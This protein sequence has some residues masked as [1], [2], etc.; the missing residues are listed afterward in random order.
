MAGGKLYLDNQPVAAVI[1]TGVKTNVVSTKSRKRRNRRRGKKVYDGI[2]KAV[3]L[4]KNNV[5]IIR[6]THL[7]TLPKRTLTRHDMTVRMTLPGSS[8][9]FNY[10]LIKLNSLEAPFSE[11]ITDGWAIAQNL[12]PDIPAQPAGRD[13]YLNNVAYSQYQVHAGKI[14]VTVKPQNVADNG[15]FFIGVVPSNEVVGGGEGAAAVAKWFNNPDVMTWDYSMQYTEKNNTRA[16]YVRCCDVE[17]LS[18]SEYNSNASY[19]GTISTEPLNKLN[20]I[21]GY[22]SDIE[23]QTTQAS[24]TINVDLCYF[25]EYFD[26]ITQNNTV[27]E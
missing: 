11:I 22:Q 2:G 10:G 26:R 18:K 23:G 12:S 7:A 24:F 13:I 27:E 19:F 14:N 9:Q 4:V 16:C 15:R 3:R 25:V 20:W 21:I 17:G 8:Q 1:G 5:K 6:P